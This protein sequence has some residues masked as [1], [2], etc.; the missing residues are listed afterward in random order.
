MVRLTYNGHAF[1]RPSGEEQHLDWENGKKENK[2]I[3]KE[4]PDLS[5]LFAEIDEAE[6]KQIMKLSFFL[7]MLKNMWM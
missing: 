1:F 2:I 6:T 5:M 3:C 7:I 4:G